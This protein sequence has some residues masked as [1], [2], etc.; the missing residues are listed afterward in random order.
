MVTAPKKSLEVDTSRDPAM[1]YL[2]E[3]SQSPTQFEIGR[4]LCKMDS[5]KKWNDGQYLKRTHEHIKLEH[6]ML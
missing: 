3:Y 4:K 2:I 1:L 6:N 5:E